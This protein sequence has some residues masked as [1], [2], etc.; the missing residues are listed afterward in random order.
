[1]MQAALPD[2]AAPAPG[3]QDA[4]GLISEDAAEGLRSLHE[5]IEDAFAPSHE[6]PPMV[7]PFRAAAERQ[8]A[9]IG[10]MDARLERLESGTE[11]A[12]LRETMREMCAAIS[13]LAA[14]SERSAGE[15]DDKIADLAHALEAQ[16]AA[17]R[18]RLNA[19]EIR[20]VDS[21]AGSV[22]HLDAMRA[23]LGQ[24]EERM[25]VGDAHNEDLAYN[26]RVLRG[27][28]AGLGEAT[29]AIRRLEERADA[30][31][32]RHAD[33]GQQAGGLKAELSRVSDMVASAA[34][35][36]E[37]KFAAADRRQEDLLRDMDRVKNEAL[38]ETA[39]AMRAHQGRMDEAERSIAEMKDRN[40]RSAERIE[41]LTDSLGSVGRKLDSGTERLAMLAGDVIKLHGKLEADVSGAQL[42]AE[43]LG[44]I[45]SWI[46]KAHERERARAELHAR[47]AD[48][49][50]P[51]A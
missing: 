32:A 5:K 21:E 26:M 31:D 10:A 11:L 22:R 51:P 23:V 29:A 36:L 44:T 2:A 30:G 19:L 18:D 47:L 34:R 25:R 49:L 20:V 41:A 37:E 43:R 4:S 7:L 15:R 12:E 17:D 24:L 8:A 27:E 40:A 3:E 39:A 6:P 46:A 35:R 42:L 13:G 45:E 28:L 48:S 38:S 33:L 1:M 50:L 14:E 9:A 16:L